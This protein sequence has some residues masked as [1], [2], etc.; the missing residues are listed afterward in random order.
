MS[1]A[2]RFALRPFGSG[3]SDITYF[4]LL[5]FKEQSKIRNEIKSQSF[6]ME[7]RPTLGID[8]I[9]NC[10]IMIEINTFVSNCVDF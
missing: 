10:S 9:V 4:F 3:M 1:G 2:C 8:F 7:F 6:R 5:R